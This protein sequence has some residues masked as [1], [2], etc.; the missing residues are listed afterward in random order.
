MS[1]LSEQIANK[2]K[3]EKAKAETAKKAKKTT[4]ES[5]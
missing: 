5:K 2:A 1:T 3:A 4:T